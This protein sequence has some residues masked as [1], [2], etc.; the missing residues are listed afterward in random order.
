MGYTVLIF[1]GIVRCCHLYGD[2]GDD[3]YGD[4]GD[5]YDD[6]AFFVE[7]KHEKHV[8]LGVLWRSSNLEP[9]LCGK[10]RAMQNTIFS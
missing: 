10:R 1:C 8:L 5:D 3:Y 7:V 4:C 9:D 6:N 2:F